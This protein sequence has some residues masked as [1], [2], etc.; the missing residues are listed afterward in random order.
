MMIPSRTAKKR[1]PKKSDTTMSKFHNE[2]MRCMT[3]RD[4]KSETVFGTIER[5]TKELERY[6][7]AI[8]RD[9]ALTL[10]N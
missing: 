7:A 3:E 10:F 5:R 2:C 8:R 1:K 6:P 4:P 9:N